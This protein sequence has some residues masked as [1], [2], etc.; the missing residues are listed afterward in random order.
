MSLAKAR[1]E[2]GRWMRTAGEDLKAAEALLDAGLYA[3]AC[4][5]SQQCAVK[6]V[7]ALWYLFDADPWGHSVQRLVE[8]FPAKGEFPGVMEWIEQA[9][10]LDKLYIPTRYPNGLPDLTPGQTY[11]AGDAQTAIKAARA[12]LEGCRKIVLSAEPLGD[13]QD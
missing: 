13:S 11:F 10:L 5:L 9:A 6:A 7:K 12:L 1:H 4:F 3:H 2:A 8:D